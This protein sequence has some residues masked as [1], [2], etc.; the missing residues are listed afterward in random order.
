MAEAMGLTGLGDGA[1]DEGAA[2]VGDVEG[3]GFALGMAPDGARPASHEGPLSRSGE[4]RA[5]AGEQ[6]LWSPGAET[7][8][9]SFLAAAEPKTTQGLAYDLSDR[10]NAFAVF[11]AAAGKRHAD[12]LA[13]AKGRLKSL[14]GRARACASSINESKREIDDLATMVNEKKQARLSS[15]MFAGAIEEMKGAEV[16]D[17]VDEEEFRLMKRQREA[18][19]IYRAA[20]EDL[21]GLRAEI[22][23]N[24]KEVN[25]LK[26]QL[27][28]AFEEWYRTMAQ[29][30]EA[31]MSKDPEDALDEQ[32]KFEKLEI[33]RV[34]NEDPDSLAFFQ[35]QKT[36]RANLTQNHIALRQMHKNKRNR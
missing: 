8:Q 17:V 32:E 34:V 16:E 9:Q 10:D 5:S 25:A 33:D 36:R 21:N 3:G 22:E 23:A 2:A 1:K 4:L 30:D 6:S 19:K 24:Q 26:Y 11:K 18:K 28:G 14:R 12:E 29:G 27:I 7:G 13:E 20:Y 15:Q 31:S 35:A